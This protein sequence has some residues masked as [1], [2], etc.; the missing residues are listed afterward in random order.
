[1]VSDTPT[2]TCYFN[3]QVAV[4]YHTGSMALGSFLQALLGMLQY[5]MG[6]LLART[7]PAQQANRALGCLARAAM[8]VLCV[9]R[10]ILA[11]I[12]RY[13]SSMQC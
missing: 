8:A 13:A 12:D 3:T 11:W 2:Y 6:F 5:V 1:M 4:V 10:T 7:R 9:L